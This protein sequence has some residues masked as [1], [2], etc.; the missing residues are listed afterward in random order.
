MAKLCV[1]E[2]P[3]VCS[4]RGRRGVDN[5]TR[6]LSSSS[7]VQSDLGSL[8]VSAYCRAVDLSGSDR[9]EVVLLCTCTE[10]TFVLQY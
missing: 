3:Q 5:F 10:V 7:T 1:Q 2:T 9:S 6:K 4:G 8:H